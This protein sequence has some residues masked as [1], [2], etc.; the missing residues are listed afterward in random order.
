MCRQANRVQITV[1][2]DTSTN[3]TV[4]AL[5]SG[6]AGNTPISNAM[7][8][9]GIKLENALTAT[10]QGCAKAVAWDGEGATCLLEVS[11]VGAR[12]EADALMAAKSVA[13]SSLAKAAIYG[14]DP[15]WGRIACAAGYSGARLLPADA[16]RHG[17][18]PW[19]AACAVVAWRP[20]A[21]SEHVSYEP[22]TGPD[23]RH[24]CAVLAD[25]ALMR[26]R[27]AV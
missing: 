10:L 21:M 20:R 22:L 5:A 23:V 2:G 11:C 26:R 27:R 12:S 25:S 3:D 4:L 14:H 13:G 7:S 8:P 19:R 9:A 1:D 24:A 17:F 18:L 16:A 6:A 15:N